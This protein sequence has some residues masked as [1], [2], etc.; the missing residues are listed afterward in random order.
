V[1][2]LHEAA[3]TC[4]SLV[5]SYNSELYEEVV[6]RWAI[7]WRG[8]DGWDSSQELGVL[9]NIFNIFHSQINPPAGRP[10]VLKLRNAIKKNYG[11]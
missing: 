8:V 1:A 11:I 6:G 4:T 10:S 3:A 7:K 5:E 9:K 2:R